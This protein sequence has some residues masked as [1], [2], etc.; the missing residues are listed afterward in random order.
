M[1]SFTL[2]CVKQCGTYPKLVFLPTNSFES[3]SS[4]MGYHKCN[5]TPGLWKYKTRPISFTLVVDDF[6]VKFVGKEL[7]II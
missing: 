5:N 6:G 1:D 7:A 4:P 3:T 2:R